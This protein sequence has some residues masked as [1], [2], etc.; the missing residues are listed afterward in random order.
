MWLS[1]QTGQHWD[2][3]G[4]LRPLSFDDW[5]T[6]PGAPGLDQL[7]GPPIPW[8][9]QGE[10]VRRCANVGLL[11]NTDQLPGH[12]ASNIEAMSGDC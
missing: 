7:G 1:V 8:R 4:V 9:R 10:R 2:D 6:R 12:L 3:Q 5:L 11:G